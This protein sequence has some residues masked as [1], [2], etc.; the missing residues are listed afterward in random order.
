M[1]LLPVFSHVL[2]SNTSRHDAIILVDP[3][4]NTPGHG[5]VKLLQFYFKMISNILWPLFLPHLH[6]LASGGGVEPATG[7]FC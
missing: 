6:V 5:L 3:Q 1:K 4:S 2:S 7:A